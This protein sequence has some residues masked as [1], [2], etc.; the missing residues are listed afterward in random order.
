MPDVH[1]IIL[2]NREISLNTPF[3]QPIKSSITRV[4]NYLF[5]ISLPRR[6]NQVLV[7]QER[8]KVGIRIAT[9]DGTFITETIVN[10]IGRDH[11]MFYGLVIPNRFTISKMRK[12]TR[13][14]NNATVYFQSGKMSTQTKMVN[15]SAGGIM[16]YMNPHL[17]EILQKRKKMTLY[18]SIDSTLLILDVRI[19]WTNTY[20]SID[21][22]GFEFY[23]ISPK[24]RRTIEQLAIKLSETMVEAVCCTRLPGGHLKE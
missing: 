2:V 15:F 1:E 16:V 14:P 5:W 13:I 18:I 10:S 11:D 8:Q 17:N 24:L 21:Y 12:Y 23:E 3:Q 6:G 4:D 20:N 19:A 22:V 7:L 9:P